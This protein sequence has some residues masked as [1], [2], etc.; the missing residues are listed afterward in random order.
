MDNVTLFN[1][2]VVKGKPVKDIANEYGISYGTLYNLLDKYEIPRRSNQ[3][4]TTYRDKEWLTNEYQIKRKSSKQIANECQVSQVL[5]AHY[6]R[7][8]QIPRKYNPPASF[9]DRDWLFDQKVNQN[10]TSKQIADECGVDRKTIDYYAKK[11]G[12][13]H[14][15]KKEKVN[16]ANIY[17]EITCNRCG[18]PGKKTLKYIQ[19]REREGKD[20]FFCSRDCTD[21]Y[22][23]EQIFTCSE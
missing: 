6:L 21:K 15:V 5:I 19:R 12:I 8:F 16:K 10:K 11:F 22:H 7:E 20:I 13:K 17:V 2:Y 23:A 18:S 3:K 9:K 1:D 4:T 14:R